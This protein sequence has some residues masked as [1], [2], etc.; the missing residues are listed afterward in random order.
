MKP[1]VVIPARAGSKGIPLKNSKLLEGKPLIYYTIEAARSVFSD[2]QILVSTDGEEIKKIVEKTGLKV[3]FLR[4]DHLAQ[5]HSGTYEV[6]LH[7]IEWAESMGYFPDSLVLLQA[8]SPF[9]NAHQIQE[10]MDLYDES[11]DMVVSVKETK[12]NPYY[13]L[14]EEN[15]SGFLEKSKNGQ[16]ARRQDAPQVYELNGAIYV[17]NVQ[18]LK[19]GP[20]SSFT[21]MKKYVMDEVSSHDID[22]QLDWLV[23]ETILQKT[24]IGQ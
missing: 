11:L 18:S 24:N 4:P 21:K 20:I 3:P 23:A 17:M 7:A 19:K 5:D 22:T 1:L 16:F 6:L 9:R 14:M 13:V 15:G 10:A 2:D 8:T 12:A